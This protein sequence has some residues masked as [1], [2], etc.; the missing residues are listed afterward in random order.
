MAKDHRYNLIKPKLTR[1]DITTFS[2][3]F[4]TLPRTLVAKDLGKEKGRFNELVANPNEFTFSELRKLSENCE[5]DIKA[6][7]ILIMNEHENDQPKPFKYKDVQLLYEEGKIKLLEHIFLYVNKSTIAKD[8]GKKRD[9]LNRLLNRVERFTFGD[10]RS[11]AELCGLT[12][13][14]M[15]MLIK[16]QLEKQHKNPG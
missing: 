1:K 13:D 14:E 11:L 2:D 10:I 5:V 6:T 3:L 4:K 16:A 15:L 9:T 8:L 12:V 7:A